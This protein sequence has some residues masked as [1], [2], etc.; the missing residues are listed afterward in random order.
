M[1]NLI[2]ATKVFEHKLRQSEKSS[3]QKHKAGSLDQD[4][5]TKYISWLTV[6]VALSCIVARERM[7]ETYFHFQFRL[8]QT[9]PTG[10]D[11]RTLLAIARLLAEALASSDDFGSRRPS[12]DLEIF[13][14]TNS[15]RV[16]GFVS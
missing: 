5:V 6:T 1:A 8:Q 11:R 14:R 7:E 4:S 9:C 15:T 10:H 16:Q 3:G 2:I 12:L 13:S